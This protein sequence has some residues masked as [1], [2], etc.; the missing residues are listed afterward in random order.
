MHRAPISVNGDSNG[1][2][3]LMTARGFF[4]CDNEIVYEVIVEWSDGGDRG[5]VEL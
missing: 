1:A 2:G 5:T 3:L 4:E